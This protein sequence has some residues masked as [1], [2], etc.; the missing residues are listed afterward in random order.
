MLVTVNGKG[1]TGKR[2]AASGKEEGF[3]II[4]LW[5]GRFRGCDQYALAQRS[6]PFDYPDC[7]L[8]DKVRRL[9]HSRT[10]RGW[11]M[12]VRVPQQ[13]GVQN[14]PDIDSQVGKLH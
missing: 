9:S 13:S 10:F 7:D 2:D 14:L 1:P 11:R 3:A 8:R 5:A 12:H 6:K 4:L